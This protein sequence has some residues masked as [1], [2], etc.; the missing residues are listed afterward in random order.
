MTETTRSEG[1]KPTACIL[2]ECNCGIEVQLGGEDG[3]RLL[4]FRGDDRHPASRGY[5]CEIVLPDDVAQEKAQILRQSGAV[6]H[7]VRPASISNRGH[8]CNVAAARALLDAGADVNGRGMWDN[9]PL[10]S[11]CQ[12][13]GDAG[14]AGAQERHEELALL[15]LARGAD[16]RGNDPVHRVVLLSPALQSQPDRARGG[17]GQRREATPPARVRR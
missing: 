1:W 12:Y 11:A 2:C 7:E 4:R 3:R 8:Y 14:G 15:L 9:T 6:V 17:H 5:A 13:A 16:V 10:I